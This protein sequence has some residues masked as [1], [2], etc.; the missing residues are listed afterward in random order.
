MSS[1]SIKDAKALTIEEW[2]TARHLWRKGFDTHD[3][4]RLLR[5]PEHKIYNGLYILKLK[6]EAA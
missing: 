5:V 2:Q 6:K 3:I 4:A 1:I